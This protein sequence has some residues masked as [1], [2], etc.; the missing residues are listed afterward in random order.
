MSE[1]KFRWELEKL[2]LEVRQ[3]KRRFYQQA[4][5]WIS[6]LSFT[7][8]LGGVVGQSVLSSIRGERAELNRARAE[9]MKDSIEVEV[10]LLNSRKDSLSRSNDSLQAQN[11]ALAAVRENLS[12]QVDAIRQDTRQ[13]QIPTETREK[14]AAAGRASY[15]VAGY[16]YSVSRPQCQ[17]MQGA[18]RARGYTV[19]RDSLLVQRPPWLA[20]QSTVFFYDERAAADARELAQVLAS[21]TG[22]PFSVSAGRGLGVSAGE[23]RYSLRVH[24]VGTSSAP[25]NE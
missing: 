14:I 3:L 21:R 13:R 1:D 16:C 4:S 19:I 15:T 5:F 17:S 20:P 6:I 22:T 12:A 2:Q 7:V 25:P 24:F 9:R 23:Q 11:V 8:A 18:I 10:R